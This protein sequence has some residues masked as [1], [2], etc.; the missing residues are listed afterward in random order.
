MKKLLVVSIALTLLVGVSTANAQV[1]P[2]NP[3]TV[4]YADEFLGADGT[5]VAT[6][7]SAL[8]NG[9]ELDTDGYVQA[10]PGDTFTVHMIV[11]GYYLDGWHRWHHRCR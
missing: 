4:L 1:D 8:Y 11:N 6:L 5:G 7:D 10:A 9:R 3:N 2:T